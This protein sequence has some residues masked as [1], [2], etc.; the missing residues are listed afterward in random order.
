MQGLQYYTRYGRQVTTGDACVCDDGLD[1]RCRQNEAKILPCQPTGKCLRR[2][3]L[4]NYNIEQS[5]VPVLRVP[6]DT[7]VANP[8]MSSDMVKDDFGYTQ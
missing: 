7:V 8:E 3:T 1:V 5:I 2:R 6:V 4:K